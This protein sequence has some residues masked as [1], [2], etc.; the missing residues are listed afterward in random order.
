[1]ATP[2][3]ERVPIDAERYD[4]T[5]SSLTEAP[6]KLDMGSNLGVAVDTCDGGASSSSR[7]TDVC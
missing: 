5:L 1:V 4:F 2:K 3:P 6:L 7:T